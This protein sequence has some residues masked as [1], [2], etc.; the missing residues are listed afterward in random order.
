M[1]ARLGAAPGVKV[2]KVGFQIM[3]ACTLG[4]SRQLRVH[5]SCFRCK[6]S[7]SLGTCRAVQPAPSQLYLSRKTPLA[8]DDVTLPRQG[9]AGFVLS[10]LDILYK[11]SHATIGVVCTAFFTP[12]G[13]ASMWQLCHYTT[14]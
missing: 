1:P 11:W 8:P 5:V 14:F 2:I 13:G 7:E 4:Y 9:W 12:F 6:F 10:S 3:L